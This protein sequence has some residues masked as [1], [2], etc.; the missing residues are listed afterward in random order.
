GPAT[1]PA[2]KRPLLQ[3]LARVIE[4]D[5]QRAAR[6]PKDDEEPNG[7]AVS[8]LPEDAPRG[9]IVPEG[10]YESELPD[11][12]LLPEEVNPDPCSVDAG[13]LPGIVVG[14]GLAK[15]LDVGIGGCVQVT[16]PT[17]GFTYV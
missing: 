14:A 4:E 17:I 9:S 5:E 3:E 7:G 6:A 16:S 8:E 10:G 11:E 13:L 15:K 2:K 1:K 12:D